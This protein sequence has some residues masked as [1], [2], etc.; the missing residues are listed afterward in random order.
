MDPPNSNLPIIGEN[1]NKRNVK[2]R[3][4]SKKQI[5]RKV[6]RRYT[7]N[8]VINHLNVLNNVLEL[9]SNQQRSI[10]EASIRPL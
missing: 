1:T 5:T 6:P 7:N 4:S 10:K 3:K 2:N 9:P 8:T